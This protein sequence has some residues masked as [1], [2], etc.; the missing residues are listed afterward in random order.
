MNSSAYFDI[1]PASTFPVQH[2]FATNDDVQS[3]PAVASRTQICPVILVL[4]EALFTG[5][6]TMANWTFAISVMN[7]LW[8]SRKTSLYFGKTRKI[9]RPVFSDSLSIENHRLSL[10]LDITAY[11]MY[12]DVIKTRQ[13]LGIFFVNNRRYYHN[14]IQIEQNRTCLSLRFATVLG[15]KCETASLV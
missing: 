4:Q 2:G 1:A 8:I 12:G 14:L 3:L 6:V 10:D 11:N 15:K 5:S 7:K 9:N 13:T